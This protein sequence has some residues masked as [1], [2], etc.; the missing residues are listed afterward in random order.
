MGHIQPTGNRLEFPGLKRID[1]VDNFS[2]G[3]KLIGD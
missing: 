1:G 3:S 2:V